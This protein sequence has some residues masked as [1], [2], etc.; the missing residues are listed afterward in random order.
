MTSDK[1]FHYDCKTGANSNPG[2]MERPFAD[3]AQAYR[4]DQ[5]TLDH[6]GKYV[7]YVHQ[8][9]ACAPEAAPDPNSNVQAAWIFTGPLVGASGV[10]SFK[11]LGEGRSTRID[12]PAG[13]YVFSLHRDAAFTTRQLTCSPGAGGGCWLSDN[14]PMSVVGV[15][16][17]TNGGNSLIDAA[18]PRA[19]VRADNIV[20]SKRGPPINIVV[21][22][23]D[24]AWANVT[25]AWTMEGTPEFTTFVQADIGSIIDL[26]DFNVSGEA[27]GARAHALFNGVVFTNTKG[28]KVLPGSKDGGTDGGGQIE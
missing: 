9:G 13:G 27:K 14:S 7:T 5:Q 28:V 15:W 6:A 3:P 25:G 10:E 16:G 21:V 12:G 2:T 26:T 1:H 4:V 20:L 17:E 22:M 18:G 8:H 23:E 19:A 11:V 24:G